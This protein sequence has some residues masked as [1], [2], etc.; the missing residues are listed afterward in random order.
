MKSKVE[1]K[2]L[3]PMIAMISS[4]KTSILNT[5]FDIDFLEA[6]SGI[7]TKF[8]NIIRYNPLVGKN[9]KFYH[10]VLEKNGDD[11]EYYKDPNFP[12]IVGKD[13]ICQ[14][15][16]ELNAE[17]KKRKD[18]PYEELFYMVEV[19]EANLIEDKEYLQNYDLV[20][21][22]GVNEYNPD[23]SQSQTIIEKPLEDSKENFS[24]PMPSFIEEIFED[25]D[26]NKDKNKS[27]IYETMEDEMA[28]YNPNQEKSY[29][30]EI[31]KIIKNKMNN[32]I[33]VFSV[34]NYQHVENYRIIAKLQK[35]IGKPIENFLIL[36]NKIDK[37]ENKD[38]D[39]NTLNNKIMKYFPSAKLFNPT[40]NLIVPCSK[41][42][43]ENESKMNKSFK[44]LLYFHFLNFI[45]YSKN[46][47][48]GTP[49]TTG[50]SFIDFLKKMINN[51]KIKKKT[52]IEKINK[53]IED[54]NLSKYLEE[55]KEI[56]KFFKLEH[57]DDN[58]NL[59]VRE[60]DFKEEEIK[61][62]QENLQTDEGEEEQNEEEGDNEDFNFYDLEG[63]VIILYYYSEFKAQ[64]NIPPKSIET[65]QIID[66]F[67]MKNMNTNLR[68]EDAQLIEETQ[69]KE[70]EQQTLNN[71]ID[72]I[73]KRM[74]EFYLKYKEEKVKEENLD[75]L[76]KYINSSIGILKT[77][78]LLYIPM[79]GVSNA[80]KS[81]ILNGII[82]SRILP[83][84]KNE[85]TKKGI[86]IKHWEKNYPVIRK[87][88]FKIEKLGKDDIYY[89]ESDKDI[90]AKGIEKIHRVLEGTNGEFSSKEEDFFYEIDINIKFVND[91]KIDESLKEK[92]CFIDLPGFGTNNEFEK[93]GV[94]SHL[95]KSC[96]IFLFVVFNLKIRESD[97]KKM[98]DELYHQ[99]S[100][101]RGIPAQAFIKKCLFIINFDKNQDTSDKSLNQAKNDIISVVDGLD[102]SMF[103]D[104]NVS[105]F[106][107][108]FYENY[109]FKLKYYESAEKL[110]NYESR[111]YKKMTQ[112]RWS[113]LIDMVKG[114]TFS[115]YLKDQLKDN[116]GN[117]VKEKFNEKTVKPNENIENELKALNNNKK[118]KLSEKDVKLISK[119]IT[120]GK[121]NISK[122]N[123]LSESKIDSFATQLLISINKAKIK[124]DEE[125]NNNIKKCFKILDDIFEVDPNTKFGSCKDAPIAKVVKPH[126]QEDLNKMKYEIESLLNTIHTEF[127]NNDIAKKL[128]K[129]SENIENSL[130]DQK[131]NIKNSLKKKNWKDI[132][133]NFE[134]TFKKETTNLE[135]ELLSNLNSFSDIIQKYL[136]QCYNHLDNFYSE[137]IERKNLLFKNYISNCL[138]GENNIE[139]T[140]KQVIDD[141]ISGS[142]TCTNYDKMDGFFNWLGSKLFDDSYLNKII[143][144]MIKN[145][146]P[147]I[148]T[149]SNEIKKHSDEFK[150]SIIDEIT[151]SKNRVVQELEE[152]KKEEELEIKSVNAQNEE[153][154]QKWEEEKEKLEEEKKKWEQLCK[155]Y[156]ILR[157]EITSLRLT[158]EFETE[159]KN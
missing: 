135:T 76:Q 65:E 146:I 152:K 26:D 136:D 120:F 89:F 155:K 7:G 20:D 53:I 128:D 34:D 144:Y 95:M 22:P 119:Y 27:Q 61:K 122:S 5:I 87:T 57:Q 43:L 99:M 40:K 46:S 100:I 51:Q 117:D 42:Q 18:V 138:G 143:D 39:L 79:L 69:K 105:F 145:S 85:C 137:P 156:R 134:E 88:K 101:Y 38:Y 121:E 113:G 10:L 13:N 1:I 91:L 123:L 28:I 83:A 96:N 58:L 132:Q 111:E 59:G 16:K 66:Y 31:F 67:T 129:C 49:T 158:K 36:L 32:G 77:S 47:N 106:N 141:I 2:N 154:R 11:Y 126:V 63:N 68:E 84:Q 114:G 9:P 41:I 4:G 98:L 142:R 21:I 118:L 116:I 25:K 131:S 52:F 90:I 110:I 93:A 12:E 70:I 73:S 48:S 55:I 102:E 97:N 92:I 78:K 81:T 107:A 3:C 50:F 149:F 103:K 124:E 30:T 115:K 17:Y 60:D 139:K 147:R 157:D 35:V 112:K 62:I 71:K 23:I 54:K 133:K 94:Y 8:I 109:I 64:K 130:K 140:I 151:S 153:E 29:L 72:S 104:L 80:G 150:K 6:V 19:G 108:K 37:S 24:A 159:G 15:N 75:N 86:L 33:I 45:L 56:I 74:E 82:G 125:I 148:N 127:S 44:H 14:K